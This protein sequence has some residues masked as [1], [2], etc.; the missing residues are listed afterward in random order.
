MLEVLGGVGER[1]GRGVAKEYVRLFEAV[2]GVERLPCAM[3][4]LRVWVKKEG[5]IMTYDIAAALER[6][7]R[8]AFLALVQ[9]VIRLFLV[10]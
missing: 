5:R 9:H 4:A 7:K 10:E 6:S 8:F 3:Q 2:F 1:A